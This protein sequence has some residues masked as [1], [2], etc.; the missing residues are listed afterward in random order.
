MIQH[1]YHER[2]G[3]YILV[4]SLLIHP[5]ELSKTWIDRMADCGVTVLGLHPVGGR[6]AA[7]SLAELLEQV[8]TPAFRALIDYAGSRG[9][10]IEYECHAV[11]YLL[12]RSLF[13]QHPEYFRVNADGERTPDWNFCVSNEA[14]LELVAQRAVEV[15]KSLYGSRPY[16]YLWLDDRRD[17]HCRCDRCKALSGSDQ[18]MLVI[19]AIAQ[20]LEK[21]NPDAKIAYLAYCG[22]VEAPAVKPHS[23]V[24]L[25]YAPFEKYVSKDAEKI[26]LEQA[27]FQG[28]VKVFG[29]KDMKILEYW[30]DNSMFSNWTKPPKE[31]FPDKAAMQ[32]DIA[33]YKAR[34]AEQIA[35]FACYLGPDYEELYEPVDIRPFT[36]AFD[37]K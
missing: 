11:G 23:N 21:W 27:A 30:Y 1:I 22:S 9:L 32:Q 15:I 19:N 2:Q 12:P 3:A 35:S 28:L 13:E 33:S 6:K 17:S 14:A 7:D 26:R 31:F 25:E 20:R 16:Y 36:E 34:G 5:D 4:T 8:K 10:E 24:F 29:K 37:N 18:Q